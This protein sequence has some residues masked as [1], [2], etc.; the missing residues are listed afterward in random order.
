MSA[1]VNGRSPT[2]RFCSG[3][4][5]AQVATAPAHPGMTLV[6]VAEAIGSNTHPVTWR[7]GAPRGVRGVS[8][9]R[10]DRPSCDCK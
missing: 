10:I 1:G 6:E 5:E 7:S 2:P 8:A 3:E 9:W 4:V